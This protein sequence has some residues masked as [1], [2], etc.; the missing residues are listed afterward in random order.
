MYE[1]YLVAGMTL[2]TF[3]IR[4][5]MF[6]CAGKMTFPNWLENALKYVPPTVLTAIIVPSVIMPNGFVDLNITNVYIPSGIF[7]LFIALKTK[8]LL[9]TVILGMTLFFILK[10]VVGF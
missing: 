10:W 8:N 5:I 7:A 1:F 3:F 6:A 2:I 4:F 9:Y